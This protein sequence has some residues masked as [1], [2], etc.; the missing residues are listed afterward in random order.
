M[1]IRF[2]SLSFSFSIMTAVR[3][4]RIPEWIARAT[5]SVQ[6]LLDDINL[7]MRKSA[8]YHE[9]REREREKL[10]LRMEWSTSARSCAS[11]TPTGPASPN[12]IVPCPL[13]FRKSILLPQCHFPRNVFAVIR[14]IGV[15]SCAVGDRATEWKYR[16]RERE[17]E[18]EFSDHS[19][20][21]SHTLHTIGKTGVV[22]LV[23]AVPKRMES[24]KR[25][26]FHWRQPWKISRAR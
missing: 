10:P 1:V 18:R 21:F 19:S 6:L 12:E 5:L 24:R 26:V 15:Q 14:L 13:A 20:T 17:R 9:E 3:R 2:L 11:A 4:F 22:S 23:N 16:E 8:Y 7:L 25:M